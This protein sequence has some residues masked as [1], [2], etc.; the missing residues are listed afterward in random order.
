M[1]LRWPILLLLISS[2]AKGGL[3]IVSLGKNYLP[4][5][6]PVVIHQTQSDR[7]GN[8]SVRNEWPLHWKEHGY[9][10]RNRDLGQ[11]FT[12]EKDFTLTAIVLRTGNGTAAFLPGA[13]GAPVFLQFFEVTGNPVIDDNGTPPGTKA[14][15]GFSTNHRCDDF[16]RGV[17]YKPLRLVRNGLMP[18]LAAGNDGRL[19]YMK[20]TLTG[21]D[22][23][24]CKAGQRYAFMIGF[25]EPGEKRAFT[26]ANHNAAGA[27][28]PPNLTDA[29]DAYHGG[30]AVRREGDGT[31]PPT[32]IPGKPRTELQKESLFPTGD[33][34][35]ALPP[36]TDGYPDV[37]TYRDL[38][39]YLIAQ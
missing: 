1:N 31:L 22:R 6:D 29:H 18:N 33:A 12:A 27:P 11:V 39:F 7:S 5:R 26:L 19:V 34:R 30:W 36:A 14:K 9:F 3:D 2:A 20:W 15:H 24:R 10:Q 25:T 21:D 23:L 28:A 38:E 4:T 8:T 37:D 17:T 13:A 35:F 32:M 16:I